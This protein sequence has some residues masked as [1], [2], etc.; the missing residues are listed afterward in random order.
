[1]SG[2]GAS[3]LYIIGFCDCTLFICLLL[4]HTHTHYCFS[5]LILSVLSVGEGGYWEGT[6][7]GH[8]GW[9][10]SDCVEEVALRSLESRSGETPHTHAHPLHTRFVYQRHPRFDSPRCRCRTVGL[11]QLLWCQ[12]WWGRAAMMT[13]NS[14]QHYWSV[15]ETNCAISSWL[16][17]PW[18][19]PPR[20]VRVGN[21]K[22][23]MYF[24]VML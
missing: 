12:T 16:N 9:F 19:G 10:P 2:H 14:L 15:R 24:P 23:D 20:S 7:R 22:S 17:S 6:V 13:I 21:L 3:G 18:F 8:T 11:P 1:M 5:L 4:T